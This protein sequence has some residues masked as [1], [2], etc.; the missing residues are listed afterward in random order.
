VGHGP[1]TAAAFSISPGHH[2]ARPQRI[3]SRPVV[4]LKPEM[5]GAIF[6]RMKSLEAVRALR[7]RPVLAIAVLLAAAALTNAALV[8]CGGG[9]S[10]STSNEQVNQT[11]QSSETPAPA[12]AGSSGTEAAGVELDGAKIYEERCA[13]CHGKTGHGDGPAAA[14]LDPKPRN[15]TDG[16][17]MNT[18]T[19][20]ELLE[21]IH[22]GKGAMPAW[23]D[24]L[25]DQQIEA[26]LK[27]V[28]SLAVP[29][30]KGPPVQVEG[31]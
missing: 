13:L 18:R 14:G 27:H 4:L 26:V 29:P 20:A 30:Y 16:T 10:S 1:A 2:G 25:T 3:P 28:R 5:R 24:V 9:G 8:G 12:E 7:A 21:V 23:K 19:N 15:H 17:Y 31:S 6:A 22:D 11:Q